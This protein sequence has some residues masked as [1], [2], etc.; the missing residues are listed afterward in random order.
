MLC[1]A[2]FSQTIDKIVLNGKPDGDFSHTTNGVNIY[3]KVLA[4]QKTGTWTETYANTE[5]PHYIIQFD[6]NKRNGLYLEFDKQ[7]GIIKKV[8]YANDMMHGTLY[9]F[10]NSVILERVD[11]QEG[12]KNGESVIY[13]EKGTMMESSHYKNNQRDGITI[14]YAN[15]DKTQGE[16]VAMYT[17]KEGV[18]DGIQETYFE[19]GKV[20]TQKRFSNNVQEGPAYEFYE[21]GSIKTEATYKNG[22]QKGKTKEYPQG[23]KFLK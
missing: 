5:L 14:W 12:V 3:G 9:K 21:D 17:Y 22:E 2:G 13:Y 7:G 4:E 6:K 10:K 18:F 23:K 20:K 11:Y 8:E 16:K 1:V 19:D 15:R